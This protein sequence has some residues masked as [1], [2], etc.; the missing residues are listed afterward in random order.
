MIT[1]CDDDPC[2]FSLLRGVCLEIGLTAR[3]RSDGVETAIGVSV[4]IL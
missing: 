1:N 3:A 2:T 4:S